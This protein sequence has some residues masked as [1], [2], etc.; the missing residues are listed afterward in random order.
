MS[1][2]A[3]LPAELL[4]LISSYLCTRDVVL[5][6][7]IC[8]YL[9]GICESVRKARQDID[10]QLKPFVP[11]PGEF[12]QLMRLTQAAI[13]GGFSLA[14][15]T[16][17]PIPTRLDVAIVDSPDATGMRLNTWLRFFSKLP[18]VRRPYARPYCR[19]LPLVS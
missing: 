15:F 6:S 19:G 7:L 12:R 11:D 17:E 10:I 18:L 3:T 2:L 14:F 1:S 16:G 4:Y 9:F 13:V 5:L 8:R